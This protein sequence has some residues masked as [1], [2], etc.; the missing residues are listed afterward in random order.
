MGYDFSQPNAKPGECVKC[1]GTGTYRWGT[2]V[3]GKCEK[4][5]PCF[6]CQGTGRQD[7]AQ[8][9]RNHGYNF[10]KVRALGI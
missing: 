1:R 4:E 6:S 9:R 7:K 2:V 8:I 5:G 10:Y 3:N